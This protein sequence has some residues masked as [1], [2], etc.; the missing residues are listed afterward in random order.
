MNKKHTRTLEN[1][2]EKPERSD[3]PWKDIEGLII[4]LGGK[5]TEGRG[6]RVRIYLNDVRAV[7]HRPHPKRVTDKGAVSSMRKFLKAAEVIK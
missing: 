5:I 4:A 6:S 1:I 7:F 2:I 3:I